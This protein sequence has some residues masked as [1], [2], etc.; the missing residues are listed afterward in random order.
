MTAYLYFQLDIVEYTQQGWTTWK[1]KWNLFPTITTF[2]EVLIIS[3]FIHWALSP[4][5]FTFSTHTTFVEVS[6]LWHSVHRFLSCDCYTLISLN[7]MCSSVVGWQSCDWSLS[8]FLGF[9]ICLS[10]CQSRMVFIILISCLQICMWDFIVQ[11]NSFTFNN[12]SCISYIVVS[13]WYRQKPM[14]LG[15]LNLFNWL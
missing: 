5:H 7:S 9:K 6:L 12:F 13:K 2:V 11:S 10:H 3:H 1:K 4:N 15:S 14:Q 8:V